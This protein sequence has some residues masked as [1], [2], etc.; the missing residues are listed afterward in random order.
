MLGGG[1]IGLEFCGGEGFHLKGNDEGVWK[2]ERGF[3]FGEIMKGLENKWFP[4]LWEKNK[5]IGV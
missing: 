2:E 3:E 4:T 1:N 5:N